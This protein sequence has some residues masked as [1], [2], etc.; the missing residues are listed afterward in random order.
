MINNPDS[1]E[2]AW[3][4]QDRKTYD[5]NDRANCVT[6]NSITNNPYIGDERNFVRVKKVDAEGYNS[7]SVDLEPNTEYQIY[8]YYNNDAK[9][10]LNKSGAGVSR[11]TYVRTRYPSYLNAG[12][13]AAVVGFLKSDNATPTEIWDTCFLNA[14]NNNYYISYVPNSAILHHFGEPG[15]ADGA[16]INGD[17]L[18]G[19]GATLAYW[20]DLWGM[21]PAGEQYS[22]CI[23]FRV[24]V[25]TGEFAVI[26]E[27]SKDGHNWHKI[28][29]ATPGETI[30]F[31]L[32]MINYGGI[33][34][35]N[36]TMH[37]DLNC[38]MEYVD[39]SCWACSTRH[40]EA[41]KSPDCIHKSGLNVGVIIHGEE[42][43]ATYKV[44]VSDNA[45]TGATISNKAYVATH[46]G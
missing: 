5:W 31:R 15:T 39:G 45:P 44:K 9:S 33:E 16:R 8:I 21:L 40:P 13:S 25:S 11:S 10:E 28:I 14:K 34:L 7:D 19:E 18:C 38:Y 6:F 36:S 24:I 37:D 35:V 26:S 30:Y 2:T 46:L 12:E 32:K 1:V 29:D 3:G 17:V 23:T 42:T 22:G 27:A 43:Y 4:P 20:D 41:G